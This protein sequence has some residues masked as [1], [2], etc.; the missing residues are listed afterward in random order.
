MP[1]LVV[2]VTGASSGLGRATARHLAGQ[3]LTVYGTSRRSGLEAHGYRMLPLDVGDDASV[4]GAIARVLDAEGRID[5]VVNNAG[6]GVSG[7][8]E[9]TSL[10]EAK[11]QFETNFFGAL[12]VIRAVLPSMRSRA[13]GSIVNIGS[14]AGLLGLPF[15]GLYSASKF[16]LEGLTEALRLEVE[17]FGVRVV[18]VDPGDFR[19]EMTA[20]RIVAKGAGD[21]AYV[22]QFRETLAVYER[23][24]RNGGDPERV[25]RLVERILHEPAPKVRYLV[26]PRGQRLAARI[27]PMVG[28]RRFEGWMRRHCRIGP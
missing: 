12:R 9:D 5:A 1:E 17:P 26:G 23:D 28:S 22:R 15:Q 13:R 7:A 14:I 24:E 6:I 3:G 25:A 20:H 2:L 18:N 4:H 21:G 8:I 19:T 16:A 10:E 27:K 11:L